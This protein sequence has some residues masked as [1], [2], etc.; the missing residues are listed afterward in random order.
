[1]ALHDKLFDYC[2][3]G[4]DPA[5]WAEPVNA[6]TNVGF[7]LAGAWAI[8]R[9]L[10]IEPGRPERSLGLALGALVVVIGAGSFLFHTFATGLAKLADVI[11]ITV[12]MIV[13]LGVA[14]RFF[15]G[16]GWL[17]ASALLLAFL[18]S[19]FIFERLPCVGPLSIVDHSRGRCLNGTIGYLPAWIAL[20]V[21]GATLTVR[22][23]A[24]ARLLLMASVVFLVSMIFR[25]LDRALCPSWSHGTHSL[26]HLLNATTLFLLLK[27]VV[28]IPPGRRVDA[29]S[30]SYLRERS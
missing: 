12:F 26:W 4:S 14:L 10:R 22:G 3:R 8:R 18:A 24:A 30:S 13:Y 19:L 25:T 5:F 29:T 16:L 15:L 20:V 28:D 27:A 7:L 17:P 21:V 23:H 11:P 2:E 1:L 9:A 6:L